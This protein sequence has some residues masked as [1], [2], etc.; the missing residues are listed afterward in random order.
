MFLPF[1]GE[2][3]QLDINPGVPLRSA[4]GY[5]LVAPA[6]RI[7]PRRIHL[8]CVHSEHVHSEHVH[9]EHVHSEHVHPKHT[10]PDNPHYSTSSTHRIKHAELVVPFNGSFAPRLKSRVK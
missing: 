9:S 3:M 5:V 10:I 2:Y 6:G 1:Q 7:H 8:W 4:P